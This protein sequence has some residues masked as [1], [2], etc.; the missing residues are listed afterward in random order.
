MNFIIGAV[1]ANITLGVLQGVTSAASG[2]YS[3][4]STI[5]QSTAIGAEEVKQII[6]DTDLEVKIKTAQL[7]LL[8]LKIKD[9]S[10]NTIKYCIQSIRNSIKDI[11]E[12]LDQIHFRMQYNSKLWFGTSV[13]A[14]RFHNNKIRLQTKLRN[15]ESRTFALASMMQIQSSM[16][17]NKELDAEGKIDDSMMNI[18]KID[19]QIAK[20]LRSDLH[21]KVEYVNKA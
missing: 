5:M 17:K 12:E 7:M 15:L 21:K 4:S 11:G 6:R 16:Y 8:E 1:G 3:V 14:Y 18:D 13:R 2:V 19:P 10:P 20:M 9:D